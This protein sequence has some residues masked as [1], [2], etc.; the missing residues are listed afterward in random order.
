ME[1]F[2]EK[3]SSLQR[4]LQ[5]MA[6]QNQSLQ[7]NIPEASIRSPRIIRR[8]RTEVNRV[9]Q[10]NRPLPWRRSFGRPGSE[11]SNV[12]EWRA[13]IYKRGL[14][15]IPINPKENVTPGNN[16]V[17]Q[18]ILQRIEPWILRELEAV[19][20]DPDPDVIV[21]VATSL[22]ISHVERKARTPSGRIGDNDNFISPLRPFLYEHTTLFWHEL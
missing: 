4:R 22:Y 1:Q 9:N 21:H 17:K 14:E 2:E 7:K 8:S 16:A 6:V 3:V 15:A 12:A 13:S 20:N 11:P 5:F 18:R 19:L 10:R